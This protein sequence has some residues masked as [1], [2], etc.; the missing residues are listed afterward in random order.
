MT[1]YGV[2]VSIEVPHAMGDHMEMAIPYETVEILM[3]TEDSTVWSNYLKMSV[4]AVAGEDISE[5]G[6]TM[7][8]YS[9]ARYGFTL[10]IRYSMVKS[11][12]RTTETAWP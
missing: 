2:I 8:Y 6:F 1:E 12:N 9:N 10:P 4:D 11:S 7:A 3:K 5:A